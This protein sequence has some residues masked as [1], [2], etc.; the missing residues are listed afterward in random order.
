MKMH[1]F[2]FCRSLH[3]RG[4]NKVSSP[5]QA[6][7]PWYTPA[8]R[9]LLRILING[10]TML[11]LV[12]MLA[13]AVLWIR[14]YWIWE[15]FYIHDPPEYARRWGLTYISDLRSCGGGVSIGTLTPEGPI[16]QVEIDRIHKDFPAYQFY[17]VEAEPRYPQV[18]LG[19]LSAPWRWIGIDATSYPSRTEFAGYTCR[20]VV[21]PFAIPVML[22]AILPAAW[23]WRRLRKRRRGPGLCAV[24]GYDLRATP[25]RCPE[26]G[27]EA[28]RVAA[29]R[30]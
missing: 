14:S 2:R 13:L 22:F 23:S 24:C 15:D 18:S 8:M 20:R 30:S 3:L 5:P 26:C 28:G 4:T 16:P 10:A 9:W 1:A 25:D 21:I 6:F 17:R 29:S 11:S 7:W 27:A 19:H 12:I